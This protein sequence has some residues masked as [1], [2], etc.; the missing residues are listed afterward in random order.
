MMLEATDLE[1]EDCNCDFCHSND[2][3]LILQGPDR[4]ERFRGSFYMVRCSNCGLIRQ[5][6]RLTWQSLKHY[7]PEHYHAFGKLVREEKHLWRRLERRYGQMKRVRSIERFKRH[8]RLLEIGCGTGLFL[9]EIL[10]SNRWEV[11]G[12]EPSRETAQYV[13]RNLMIPVH[14]Q[15]FS[16]VDF[17][18]SSFDVIVLWN[19]L[20]HLRFPVQDLHKIHRLLKPDGLLVFS[21]PNLESLDARVFGKYWVGWEL[22][23]HLYLFPQEQLTKVLDSIGFEFLDKRFGTGSHSALRLSLDFWS[24][25]WEARHPKLRRNLLA[26]YQSLFVRGLLFIPLAIQDRLKQ[27][28]LMTVYAR[29]IDKQIQHPS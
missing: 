9:E 17:E 16:D 11:V 12:V 20:E 22:P 26:L 21:I 23:R 3:E 18:D 4:G 28:T 1:W 14:D 6:P 13:H 5:N 10:R 15:Q 25:S 29:K 19:V 7:Y 27:S 2:S 24:Q 8:G